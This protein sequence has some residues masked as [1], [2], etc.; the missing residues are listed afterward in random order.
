MKKLILGISSSIAAYKVLELVE[1]LSDDFII[2]IIFTQNALH[3]V[4]KN[5]F[6]VF[7]H[8]R[9]YTK[10]FRNNF[11]YKDYIKENKKIDHISLADDA[12]LFMIIPAT[13]N[14]IGKLAN[15]ICDDLLTT[16]FMASNCQKIIAPAMNCKMWENEIL[17]ENVK[18]LKNN[19]IEF[20]DPERGELACGYEGVGRLA[21]IDTIVDKIKH[22]ILSNEDFKGKKILITAGP[23]IE[24]I[25]PVRF[26]S[27][28][29]TGK[30]GYSL[31][32]VSKIRGANVVLVTGPTNLVDPFGVEVIHVS[33]ANQMQKAVMENT[34][35]DIFISAAAVADYKV[36]RSDEKIKK[37]EFIDLRLEKNPDI[38]FEF[39]KL[40]L[41]KKILVG[42]ALETQDIIVNA[43]EKMIKKNLDI[44]IAN[45]ASAFGSE[46]SSVFI[47]DK[48]KIEEIKTKSKLL[49]AKKILD[50]ISCLP[51]SL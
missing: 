11:N 25:D 16:T 3:L 13:A 4:D 18:R 47:I 48:E 2:S 31:A 41:T 32:K 49:I 40:D 43:K 24:E 30:M 51:K 7:A 21:K 38:L 20:I 28:K 50:A 46:K 9:I 34:D 42:F 12:D 1:K 22:S 27:N 36:Q 19:G 37:K 23:T 14:V 6:Q 15:G 26:I 39:S 45:D 44:I 35:C 33:N 17:Q 10:T 8:N 29:S 5:D